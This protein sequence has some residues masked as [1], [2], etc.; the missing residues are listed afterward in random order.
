MK[1]T[2]QS[3]QKIRVIEE[4][5]LIILFVSALWLP[6][7]GMIF[8]VGVPQSSHENRQLA[9]FPP[10]STNLEALTVF[11][12]KFAAYF[13]DN[14]SF[15]NTLIYW[16]ANVKVNWLNVSPSPFVALGKDGWLFFMDE[17]SNDGHR[18]IPLFTE[19]QLEQ[20]KQVLEA[21][22]DWLAQHG[23]RYLFVIAPH[24]QT[25]YPE[26]LPDTFAEVVKESRLRQLI[27]YLKEHSDV[28][29]LDL[30]PALNEAKA[31]HILYHKTDS[32]WNYYGGFTAYQ[33]IIR[34]LAKSFPQLQPVSESDCEVRTQK[35]SGDLALLLGL[36]GFLIEE[37]PFIGLR[38]P[39]FV[40][41]QV[42]ALE[43]KTVVE[44]PILSADQLQFT[45]VPNRVSFLT[46]ERKGSN[47]PRVVLF[48]DS[49]TVFL[50]PFFPE[51]FSRAVLTWTPYAPVLD[52]DL[53]KSEHPDVVVQEIGEM[54]L[55]VPPPV[56]WPEIMSS[57]QSNRRKARQNSNNV[58]KQPPDY[59]GFHDT[60]DC[61]KVFGWAWDKNRPDTALDV[62]IYDGDTLIAKVPADLYRADLP[63]AGIGDGEHG[64]YYPLPNSLKD[65]R[66]HSIRVKIADSNFNLNN[67][68]KMLTCKP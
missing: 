64:F 25:I 65:G 67:T 66:P 60:A 5:V 18:K 28:D 51:H 40:V 46:T 45:Y 24:K 17:F 34:E 19:K 37:T 35:Y 27:A 9:A 26:Y 63:D 11:P 15:R 20:W 16:Q 12:E 36:G 29:F 55:M 41:T 30:R 42:K 33:S 53:I 3:H 7:F 59:N 47:L 21:R 32:H 58:S 52:L 43:G 39:S 48:H 57:I 6:I 49:M 68:P 62:E 23:I 38:K 10:L 8:R 4:A 22:R 1:T 54:F 61:E 31:R 44:K 13:N 56:D 50:A 2:I 14:F